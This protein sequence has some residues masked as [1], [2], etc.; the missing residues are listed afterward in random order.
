MRGPFGRSRGLA[1]GAFEASS[2]AAAVVANGGTVSAG[3]LAIVANFVAA[4]KASG[5][6]ALTDD[7]W[8]LWGENAIQGLTSLKQKRLAVAVN[9]PAF[10]ASR[11]YAFNG[12]TQYV[13]TG[14][15]SAS[16]A[17]AMTA[18]NQRLAVYER[19][20]VDNAGGAAAGTTNTG[21]SLI[22]IFPRGTTNLWFRINALENEA[23]TLPVADS[24]GYPAVSVN[25]T[26][27]ADYRG[28]KNGVALSIV[29]STATMGSGLCAASLYIGAANSSG[30]ALFRASS[31]GF[32]AT[33]ATLTAAQEAAQYSNVQAWATAV[34]ANV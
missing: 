4:E 22:W 9:S 1:G 14:F 30:P 32:A 27:F 23:F 34:G 11:G 20:D 31:L 15:A 19:T 29:V 6:W 33:G 21:T 2:W 7:Y 28:Y 12:T 8:P 25:G 26:T 13:D 5:G 17:L 16:N 3:R 10:T 24:R 18:S